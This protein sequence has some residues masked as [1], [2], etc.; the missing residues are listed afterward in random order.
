MTGFRITLI[1]AGWLVSDRIVKLALNLFVGVLIARHLGPAN[2]GLL[3]Y[4]QVLMTLL[5]P[6]ATFGMPEILVREL[7]RSKRDPDRIIATALV[8][9]L[10]FAVVA[11]ACIIG[12]AFILRHDNKLA[13]LVIASYGLSFI[14]Q[15]F[16]VIESRFQSLNRVKVI[17]SIR[18]VNTVVFSAVRLGALLMDMSVV[19]FALLYSVEILVFSIVSVIVSRRQG[20]RVRATLWDTAEARSLVKDSLPLMIRLVAIGVYM[21]IDQ[22]MIQ[23]ILGARDLGIYSAA[24]RISE[25]WYFV[26]VAI[27]AAAAPNLTRRYEES[28]VGYTGELQRLLR[29]M[30]AMSVVVAVLMT[31][32]SSLV[33]PLLFGHA[34]AEAAPVLAIQAWAGVFVAVGVATSPWFVNTGLMRYGVYQ[35]VAGMITSICANFILLPIYGLIGSAI[36]LVISYAV[37]AVFINACFPQTRSLFAMQIK[38]FLFR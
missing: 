1:N 15:S 24:T 36:S 4:G 16:D 12:L 8:L 34:Y 20:L 27:V 19:W 32:F 31:A 17:S 2:F 11:L 33:V 3:S 38:A 22:V 30:V 7:S 14:P 25:I 28:V 21:R 37:S 9:R 18:M 13:I 29:I 5:L 23:H 35:A 26:P 10:A 6:V